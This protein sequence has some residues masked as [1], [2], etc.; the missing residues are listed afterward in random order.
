MMGFRAIPLAFGTS[1]GMRSDLGVRLSLN[2]ELS[3]LLLYMRLGA[4]E[5]F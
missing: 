3:W 4:L 1:S 5:T 2:T